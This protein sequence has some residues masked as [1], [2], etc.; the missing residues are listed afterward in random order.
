[1]IIT[2]INNKIK[3]KKLALL[4]TGGILLFLASCVKQDFDKPPVGE[5]PVGDIY[6]I[7]QLRQMYA[8]SGAYQFDKDASVYA[9]VTMDESSGNIYKSAY[10]QDADDAVNLHFNNTG[11]LRVGDSIRVYLKGVILSEYHGMFQLDNVRNDSSIVIL[12][13]QHYVEPLEVTIPDLLSGKYQ[14]KLIKLSNVQF[15]AQDITKTWAEEDYSANRT[16]EDCNNNQIDVRTSSYASFALF[17]LPDSNG[18]FIAIAGSYNGNAQLYVRT[19]KELDMH[20]ERCSGSDGVTS[21]NI[22][23]SDQN[24]YDPIS[25]E[26]WININTI[27]S[28]S[29]QAKEYNSNI[30]AQ[31]TSYGSEEE[32]EIWLITP[33]INLAS[34]N[35]PSFIFD[36]ACAYWKHDGLEV[37]ISTDFDGA[38]IDAANWTALNCN[39]PGQGSTNYEFVSSG[40]IDLSSYSGVSGYAYIAF[41]YHGDANAGNTTS[42]Q[43]DNIVLSDN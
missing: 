23:F 36:V 16:L 8:D 28:R 32:N 26:G 7:A 33:R 3:M 9:T 37:L 38:N 39:I 41:K 40:T 10:I 6:T 15:A 12:A 43:I 13:T 29:W 1:M 24:N 25:I 19:P 21:F 27:G 11:G 42:Y 2:K 35:N 4:L 17:P 14:A 31:A 20:N 18:T 34:M 5:L 22:D 30:Y